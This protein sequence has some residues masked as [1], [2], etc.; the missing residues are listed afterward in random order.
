MCVGNWGKAKSKSQSAREGKVQTHC[1]QS[2]VP[3]YQTS[4][5]TQSAL[6]ETG[7]GRGGVTQEMTPPCRPAKEHTRNLSGGQSDSPFQQAPAICI[8]SATIPLG[9]IYPKE[10]IMVLN[11]VL[12][13]KMK[14][15]YLQQHDNWK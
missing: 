8:F 10:I 14:E 1:T 11:K 7:M 9:I 15:Q 5:P 3:T 6:M 13:T 2:N 12:T 4:Q